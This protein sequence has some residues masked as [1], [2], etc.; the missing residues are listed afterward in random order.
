MVSDDIRKML[1][2]ID[3]SNN[4]AILNKPYSS[5]RFLQQLQGNKKTKSVK[6]PLLGKPIKKSDEPNLGK[7]IGEELSKE[8]VE[9]SSKILTKEKPINKDKLDIKNAKE[10]IKNK[11]IKQATSLLNKISLR[12]KDKNSKTYKKVEELLNLIANQNKKELKK[13][14]KESLSLN[15]KKLLNE[16]RKV[17]P[18][19]NIK[20]GTLDGLPVKYWIKNSP[21]GIPISLCKNSISEA[22]DEAHSKL[23]IYQFDHKNS[24]LNKKDGG[25]T[26]CPKCHKDRCSE[27]GA[28]HNE[29][30]TA[31]NEDSTPAAGSYLDS[32]ED[33]EWIK[34]LENLPKDSTVKTKKAE[35]TKDYCIK[36]YKK[37][38]ELGDRNSKKGN[39]QAAKNA[40]KQAND[41][42]KMAKRKLK[43]S[44][45]Q[46]TKA[47]F[48]PYYINEQGILKMLFVISSNP[49]YGG[50]KPM[51][52]KGHV[53]KGETPVQAGLREAHE[54]CGLKQNNLKP[55]TIK[56]GWQGKITGYTETS[57]MD[58]YIGEV[59][60]PNDFDK[61]GFEV[62][63]TFWLTSDEFNQYGRI[64]QKMIVQTCANKVS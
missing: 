56:L 60:N 58:I 13:K 20:E 62:S 24:P 22:L 48:I 28:C 8:L 61:P 57:I 25:P 14:V 63:K 5:Y 53:D 44:V 15:N 3:E 7:L 41:F 42:K 39:L 29:S 23:L 27:C 12:L 50:S 19:A 4:K 33:S 31:L 59:I 35:P 64:S 54:E 26:P 10:L 32:D 40:Y 52:A 2:L 6:G 46:T 38:K 9:S 16:I 36:M 1:T 34:Y 21:S 18:L 55:N 37:W 47:G 17:Y 45:E 51:I 30:C 43:E 49:M 11:K